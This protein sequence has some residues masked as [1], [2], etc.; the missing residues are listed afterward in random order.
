MVDRMEA[1]AMLELQASLRS[2]GSLLSLHSQP[3]PE[4]HLG[5]CAVRQTSKDVTLQ[6]S[7]LQHTLHK[8]QVMLI[9]NMVQILLR[10]QPLDLRQ[11]HAALDNLPPS[12]VSASASAATDHTKTGAVYRF[13]TLCSLLVVCSA[14]CD[15]VL[16]AAKALKALV[17]FLASDKTLASHTKRLTV[18]GQTF[19]SI[20]AFAAILQV[21][22][23]LPSSNACSN[24]DHY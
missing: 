12:N 2:V 3:Q 22:S 14:V 21:I 20:D 4:T 11:W 18:F 9:P 15:V 6:A 10:P 16:S 17:D 19:H 5:C 13:T 23:K 8:V 7:I 1:Q 24:P